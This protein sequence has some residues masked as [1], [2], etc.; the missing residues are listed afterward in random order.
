MSEM[1]EYYGLTVKALCKLMQ[2]NGRDGIIEIN[3]LGGVEEI[4][5]KL[6]TS[7]T[8]GLGNTLEHRRVTFGSN[9]IPRER[10]TTF[11]ELMWSVFRDQTF[12]ILIIL[13]GLAVYYY[14]KN[15]IFAFFKVGC[16]VIVILVTVIVNYCTHHRF[17]Y[18]LD[19]VTIKPYEVTVI[20]NALP[21]KIVVNDV[22]VGDVC[23]INDNDVVPADGILIECNELKI[24][25][26]SLTGNSSYAN[27]SLQLDAMVLGGTKV[28]NGNGTMVVVAVG[29]NTRQGIISSLLTQKPNNV[30]GMHD[31][32]S[33]ILLFRNEKSILQQ[34]TQRLFLNIIYISLIIAAIIFV[35]LSALFAWQIFI[36]QNHSWALS[37]IKNF[38]KLL[39]ISLYVFLV[40]LPEGIPLT[41]A[42]VLAITIQKLYRDNKLIRNLQT[43]ETMGNATSICF[44]KTGTLTTNRMEIVQ[45][46]IC[47][48]QQTWDAE[49]KLQT[50]LPNNILNLIADNI[51][52]N[53]FSSSTVTYTTENNVEQMGNKTE[54]ALLGLVLKLGLNFQTI[55]ESNSSRIVHVIP[56]NSDR[57]LMGT[58][59]QI[60]DGYRLFVKGASDIVLSKCKFM[61]GQNEK[62]MEMTKELRDRITLDVIKPTTSNRLRTVTLG[63]RDFVN[64][65]TAVNETFM[66]GIGPDWTDEINIV[67]NLTCIGV[68]AIEDPIRCDVPDLVKKLHKFEITLRMVTGDSLDTATSVAA[69]CGIIDTSANVALD[70]TEFNRRIRDTDGNIKQHLFDEVYPTLRVL[71]R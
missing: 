61:I 43:S 21:T 9:E 12:V 18:F 19:D 69:K 65:K 8:Q 48:R 41:V 15:S 35:L 46:Y 32:D 7:P 28:I 44:D 36:I 2:H 56:F 13:A 63:Y 66:N 59:I 38:I 1:G 5:E 24:D 57:K 45:S 26:S 53:S 22:V 52:I 58:V 34:K 55:R 14:D 42:I 3:K 54:C 33:Q 31:H 51:S 29:M 25:E 17:Q 60:S 10:R 62:L 40:A 71:A 6:G 68:F 39:I 20:R 70:A 23:I 4:C 50:M 47:E 37:Y 11:F 49:N 16:V 67:K 27:K 30:T 64:D